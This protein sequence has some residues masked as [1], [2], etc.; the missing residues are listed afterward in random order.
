MV[1]E[2][3]ES[4]ES[5]SLFLKTSTLQNVLMEEEEKR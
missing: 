2:Q 3:V 4:E 1:K 5:K